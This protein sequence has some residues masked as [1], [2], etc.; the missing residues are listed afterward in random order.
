MPS[1]RFP[2]VDLVFRPKQ[3]SLKTVNPNGA[4]P[5]QYRAAA[6]L[7]QCIDL[8]RVGRHSMRGLVEAASHA[9][10]LID[11][12]SVFR[13]R[14]SKWDSFNG[15]QAPRPACAAAI[16][17][18][19]MG[20]TA[21]AANPAGQ[22]TSVSHARNTDA[23]PL[24]VKATTKPGQTTTHGRVG[25][26]LSTTKRWLRSITQTCAHAAAVA[27]CSFTTRTAIAQIQT[28]L[29]SKDCANDATNWSV[30]V[31][32]ISRKW[33]YSGL[34]AAPYAAQA[35]VLQARA[36]NAAR[37][38]GN[39]HKGIVSAC[40]KARST[41]LNYGMK[42]KKLARGLNISIEEAEDIIKRYF[43]T[44]PAIEGFY[45]SAKDEARKTGYSSTI[46]GRRRF[47]PAINSRNTMDRWGEERKAVNNNIQGS[48][49][50]CVRLAMLNIYNAG[51]EQ[52]YDCKMLL[53][54]HDEL[55]FECDERSADEAMA[56]I[57][58]TMEHPFPTELI[59]PLT[60]SIGKG[61]SWDKA[62]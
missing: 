35:T 30:N 5:R 57:K 9:K 38:V 62:K 55:M 18:P 26:L 3:N 20:R 45:E 47:H 12:G 60:V 24:S 17:S 31:R 36:V 43:A 44:Y 6:F 33:L 21:S 11:T 58:N 39:E 52:K 13:I 32:A 25:A 49:A 2:S 27:R 61:P 50:D 16:G 7:Q 59:V 10:L 56:E 34:G 28:R 14:L 48:A 54:V 46:L 1:K 4:C 51:I 19:Q 53:Q 15:K 42:E 29:I 41:T 22:S 37:P 8:W 23:E 40:A